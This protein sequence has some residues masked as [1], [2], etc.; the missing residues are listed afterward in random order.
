M[1]IMT[2]NEI[3]DNNVGFKANF[4]MTYWDEELGTYFPTK[5]YREE[6]NGL[7]WDTINRIGELEEKI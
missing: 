3:K 7:E 4:R 5:E 1:I 2:E 6:F